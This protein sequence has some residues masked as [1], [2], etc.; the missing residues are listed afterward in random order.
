MYFL[1]YLTLQGTLVMLNT[2][3]NVED[4]DNHVRWINLTTVLYIGESQKYARRP[5][6][7]MVLTDLIG[8]RWNKYSI[9]ERID[10]ID[11]YFQNNFFLNW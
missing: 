7:V 10:R 2:L 1:A 6:L 5:I 4:H 8:D 3:L 9:S 11:I